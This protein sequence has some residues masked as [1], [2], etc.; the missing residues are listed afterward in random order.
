MEQRRNFQVKAVSN[1]RE[2]LVRSIGDHPE[3]CGDEQT[4]ASLLH[5]V[6]CP[7]YLMSLPLAVV[8]WNAAI[9]GLAFEL[10]TVP[11]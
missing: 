1:H 11:S 2:R 5:I 10:L 7:L 9:M 6:F 3:P 4:K 8:P